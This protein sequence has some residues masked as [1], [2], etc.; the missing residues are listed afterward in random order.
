MF[1][2]SGRELLKLN[3]SVVSQKLL[4]ISDLVGSSLRAL[5]CALN[6]ITS[7]FT[8]TISAFRLNFQ[9]FLGLQ[10]VFS[11]A[12]YLQHILE[13]KK[14]SMSQTFL[15]QEVPAKGVVPLI[16]PAD[17]CKGGSG[18]AQKPFLEVFL[19]MKKEFLVISALVIFVVQWIS[20]QE[21]DS[22]SFVAFFFIYFQTS[23]SSTASLISSCSSTQSQCKKFCL[24]IIR[25]EE[26]SPVNSVASILSG[27][28]LGKEFSTSILIPRNRTAS[29]RSLFSTVNL[30]ILGN[31]SFY[32]QA[33][34]SHLT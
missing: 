5:Q 18:K 26:S 33:P 13:G 32:L 28:K 9:F 6:L 14:K 24:Y 7:S 3:L 25:C 10:S 20:L 22:G 2:Q 1:S 29:Y 31:F 11:E 23:L 27:P 34:Q 4:E 21:S 16:T 30:V 12:F 15:F 19:V 8:L 17:M